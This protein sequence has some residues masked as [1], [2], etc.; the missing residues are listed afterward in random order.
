MTRPIKVV[1]VRRKQIDEDK[2]AMALL[3]LAKIFNENK[4][5][6]QS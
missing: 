5:P 6:K 3:M 2:L 4:P 1:G